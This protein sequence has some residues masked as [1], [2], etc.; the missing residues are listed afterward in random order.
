MVPLELIIKSC[1]GTDLAANIVSPLLTPQAVDLLTNCLTSREADL[2][3]SL[4]RAWN[5]PS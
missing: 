3:K 1:Q 5:V 4:G 2:W